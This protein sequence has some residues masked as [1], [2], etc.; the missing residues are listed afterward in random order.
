MIIITDTLKNKFDEGAKVA[1]YNLLKYLKEDNKCLIILV[2]SDQCTELT[3]YEITTNKLLFNKK[4]YTYVRNA[5]LKHVLYI[6]EASITFASFL[7]AKLL[8][9]FGRAKVVILS[10]QPRHYSWLQRQIIIHFLKPAGIITQ[11]TALADSLDQMGI[12]SS[13]I[14]LG[15]NTDKF[16]ASSWERKKELRKKYSYPVDKKIMLHVGHIKKSRNLEWLIEVKKGLP[17]LHILVVGSTTTEKDDSLYSLLEEND[18]IVFREFISAIE[19]MYQLAD[20]YVFPVLDDNAAI[21]TPLSVLEAMASNLPV[22]TTRFGSLPGSFAET[23]HFR[24]VDSPEDIVSIL[25]NGFMGE[26]NT[27]QMVSRFSWP[28]IARDLHSLIEKRA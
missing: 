4:I 6:P 7:R 23:S 15:V 27:R 20:Y 5:G 2:N 9:I 19:E 8:Q 14:P 26:S 3:D 21:E 18:V 17:D 11:S 12:P 25:E 16:I 1:V 10:F 28:A 22:L 24:Y 13:Y